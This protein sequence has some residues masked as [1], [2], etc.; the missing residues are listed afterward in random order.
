[1]IDREPELS[2]DVGDTSK[3]KVL[4]MI[5]SRAV[6]DEDQVTNVPT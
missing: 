5:P 3:V 4:L 1:M 2:S 6:G